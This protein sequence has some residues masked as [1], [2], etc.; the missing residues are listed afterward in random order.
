MYYYFF[1]KII[2]YYCITIF[3]KK[4]NYYSVPPLR[5]EYLGGRRKRRSMRG[6]YNVLRIESGMGGLA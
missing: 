1:K 4:M 5:Y 3:L 6:G 2:L